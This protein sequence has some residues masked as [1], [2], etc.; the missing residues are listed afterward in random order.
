MAKAPLVPC[1]TGCEH[2]WVDVEG[3]DV[4]EHT[5]LCMRGGGLRPKDRSEVK[6]VK[7]GWSP[8]RR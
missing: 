1:P 6:V 5:E 3:P 4:P 2:E 8:W 7:G